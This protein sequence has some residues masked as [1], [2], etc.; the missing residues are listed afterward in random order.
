MS[1]SS[2]FLTTD[3]MG[4][5]NRGALCELFLNNSPA[6]AYDLSRGSLADNPNRG[7]SFGGHVSAC[8]GQV[9]FAVGISRRMMGFRRLDV[10]M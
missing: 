6:R 7:Q 3:L 10:P 2:Q 4:S 9:V 8:R 1:K 5:S